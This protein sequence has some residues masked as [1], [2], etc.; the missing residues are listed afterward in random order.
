MFT[1]VG[2]VAYKK[3]L[4]NT[5]ALCSFCNNPQN[6]FKSIHIAG[7]NGK[8][9]SS[10]A[11]ASIFQEAG[12]K[13]GLYTSPHL[14]DFRERIKINGQLISEEAVIRFTEKMIPL[15]ESI[16]PSFF[17][18][19]VVMAFEYFAEEHVDIAIIETGMGGR[20]DS[21]NVVTPEVSLITNIGWDHM[22][23]LGTT[24]AAI[25]GEKAGIIKP[26][27]PVVISEDHI[28]TRPVFVAKAQAL[29]A[30]ITF[31]SQSVQLNFVKR[32]FQYQYF[33][34]PQLGELK[35]DLLGAYQQKNLKGIIKT[36]ETYNDLHQERS[37]ARNA[38][39]NGLAKVSKQTGLLGRWQILQHQPLVV[40][41]TGHNE[42]GIIEIIQMLSLYPYQQLWMVIGMVKDKSHDK[43]LALL[44]K[45]AHY[46]FCQADIPRALDAFAL[47][48]M[49]M[50]YG[51]H[52][53]VEAKVS[54]AVERALQQAQV[55]DMIFI[56]GSTFVVADYLASKF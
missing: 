8:G 31:A 16:E 53:E 25:A 35:L 55:D 28:D 26:H 52:G 45:H 40:C 33:D 29:N 10:H 56:G 39:V 27:V 54:H 5:L 47:Q 48:E 22:E 4:T 11:L 44:P 43:I 12:F 51:L 2:A 21:T 7:T 32:D 9:S 3:D 18:L 1:R 37:I 41:D 50:I 24:L 38:I 42:D 13:T 34:H 15:I 20:L 14:V 46:M 30:P 36:I 49:A 17:E 23:F 19:T 6:R